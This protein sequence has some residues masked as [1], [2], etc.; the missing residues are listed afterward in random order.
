MVAR[1]FSSNET[2][3]VFCSTNNT[4]GRRGR[5][6]HTCLA[7]RILGGEVIC[8][9]AVN[10]NDSLSTADASSGSDVLSKCTA[11]S[12]GDTVSTCASCL[13]VFT[14]NVVRVGVYAER[15]SLST[16]LITDCGVGNDTG[17]FESCVS[18]LTIVVGTKFEDNREPPSL[19]STAVSGVESKNSIVWNTADILT[20]GIGRSLE[21]A[22]HGCGLTCHFQSSKHPSD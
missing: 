12:L 8:C 17:S 18:D 7:E 9:I 11:H 21:T 4:S 22:I 19:R 3:E 10:R 1:E 6:L 16:C 13:F 2:L 15:I 14:E 20:S 5:E